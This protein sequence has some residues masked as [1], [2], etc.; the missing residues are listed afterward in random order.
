MNCLPLQLVWFTCLL[1]WSVRC[2]FLF[3]C[4]A[5]LC[6]ALRVCLFACLFNC[7]FACVFVCSLV[8]LV[9]VS[10]W[11]VWGVLLLFVILRYSVCLCNFACVDCWDFVD[12]ACSVLFW[13]VLLCLCCFFCVSC[14]FCLLLSVLFA[15]FVLFCS[16]AFCFVS[17][18]RGSRQ[19]PFTKT[20]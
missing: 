2:L 8:Y 6:F 10:F 5:L 14:V 4:F 20:N 16:D 12:F 1:Y 3:V 18:E 17:K 15:L 7:L 13:R 9:F 11:F 19:L